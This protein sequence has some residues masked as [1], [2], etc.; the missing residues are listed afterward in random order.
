MKALSNHHFGPQ[1]LAKT[2]HWRYLVPK[3]NF[4]ERPQHTASCIVS[5]LAG[6]LWHGLPSF[7][8]LP[9]S[10]SGQETTG[11]GFERRQYNTS[12]VRGFTAFSNSEALQP[13]QCSPFPWAKFQIEFTDNSSAASAVV[14]CPLP[15]QKQTKLVNTLVLAGRLVSSF[16]HRRF[17]CTY[18]STSDPPCTCQPSSKLDTLLLFLPDGAEDL[19]LTV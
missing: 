8:L 14:R 16:G 6:M 3:L 19:Y 17:L 12:S 13:F 7:D 11:P 5:D 2:D 18:H 4:Q 9:I 1:F 10:G 15:L